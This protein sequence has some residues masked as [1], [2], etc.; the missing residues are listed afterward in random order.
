MLSLF[1]GKFENRTALRALTSQDL[2]FFQG[3]I[4][5]FRYF[6]EYDRHNMSPF[7]IY[8]AVRMM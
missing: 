8:S 5:L 6:L 1:I 4:E 3:K 7:L 2:A